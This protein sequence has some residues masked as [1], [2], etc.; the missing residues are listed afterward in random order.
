MASIPVD[1]DAVKGLSF[2]HYKTL[3]RSPVVSADHDMLITEC[4]KDGI[5]LCRVNMGTG[6]R[7]VVR[8]FCTGDYVPHESSDAKDDDD[9]SS[10]S[11]AQRLVHVTWGLSSTSTSSQSSGWWSA[12][13][14]ST[15]TVTS[16]H[17]IA[18]FDTTRKWFLFEDDFAVSFPANMRFSMTVK[19]G[20]WAGHGRRFFELAG[21]RHEA[22]TVA[23]NVCRILPAASV[24]SRLISPDGLV[25]QRGPGLYVCLGGPGVGKTSAR[26]M[27]FIQ[28]VCAE[29]R[30]RILIFSSLR[31]V[32]N[33]QV[34][35][36]RSSLPTQT[37]DAQV[38]VIGNNGLDE[39][40]RSRT[41]A[42]LVWLRMKDVVAGHEE[43]LMQLAAAASHVAA[44]G[45]LSRRL[46]PAIAA[47][48]SGFGAFKTTLAT[49]HR[50]VA[51]E[52]CA[53]EAHVTTV[54]RAVKSST[55]VV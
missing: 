19:F 11:Q 48:I 54:G 24:F 39:L 30:R 53:L 31:Q 6:S 12:A 8:G 16:V 3:G 23:Q 17:Y 38:R 42:A 51:L 10:S 21:D 25:E 45:A 4:E 43:R 44:L 5:Q 22:T 7:T 27:E 40:A 14:A 28:S 32:R 46:G 20:P 9:T 47:V 33:A 49:M 18:K 35:M 36:M 26:I 52:R 29:G 50:I 41:T 34:G 15:T 1:A 13:T 55:R 37:F 2:R